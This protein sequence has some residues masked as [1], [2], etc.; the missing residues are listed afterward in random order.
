MNIQTLSEYVEQDVDD[1][2]AT[3]DIAR[4]FNKGIAQYNLLSPLTR[5]PYISIAEIATAANQLYD[6]TT[7]YP[8]PDTFM[9]GVMLPFVSASVRGS[10]SAINERQLHLSDFIR[11]AT[12]FKRSIDIPF[13]WMLNDKNTDLSDFEIGENI[14]LSDF[15]R[16]PFAGDWRR[17]SLFK[18]PFPDDDY[19]ED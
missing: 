12:T 16:A 15:N 3:A 8:L 9:L 18:E 1:S 19:T 4:W 14:Y 6:E 10:E 5:Y 2:F 7:P 13:E 17:S 11:N